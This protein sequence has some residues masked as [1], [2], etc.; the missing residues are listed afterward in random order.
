[1][2]KNGLYGGGN[3]FTE[4]AAATAAAWCCC[5]GPRFKAH[6]SKSREFEWLVEPTEGEGEPLLPSFEFENCETHTD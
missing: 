2:A 6:A 1:M 3:W 5:C 4:S